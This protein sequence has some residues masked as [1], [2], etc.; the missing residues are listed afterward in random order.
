MSKKILRLGRFCQTCFMIGLQMYLV[1]LIAYLVLRVAI[2]DGVWW[3]GFL[4]NLAPC[5]FLPV[6][7]L[8]PFTLLARNLVWAA[9]LL[10]FA[11]LAGLWFGPYFIP[12]ST[13]SAAGDTLRLATFN[14]WGDNPRMAD[15]AAWILSTEAD[16]VVMQEVHPDF[17]RN[18]W[19]GET[20]PYRFWQAT[21]QDWWANYTLS[22]F[23]ILEAENLDWDGAEAPAQQRLVLDVNGQPVAL[24]NLHLLMPLGETA[25][26]SLPLD[27][28]FLN[29]ALKYDDSARNAQIRRLLARLAGEPYPYL[30]AGDFN[31][32]DQTMI[33]GE[34]AAVMRDSFREAG[35]GFGWSWPAGTADD[36]STPVPLLFRLDYIWHSDGF[37]ALTAQQGPVL[38]SDHLPLLAT[39]ELPGS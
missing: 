5:F 30:V 10:P 29:M 15:V 35:N 22:R 14:V 23:P 8:L 4:N 19:L 36:F 2:G 16:V 17:P 34:L 7:V 38:G 13:A 24:Y 25:H 12:R 26:L 6:V 37:R 1:F 18:D 3:L 11:L 9:R 28:P 21:G 32:S 20:Y 27:N 33:Y 39:L 31:M